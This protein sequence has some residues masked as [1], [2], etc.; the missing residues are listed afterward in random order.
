MKGI[1][2]FIK[3]TRPINLLFIA[4]TAFAVRFWLLAPFLE[5]I[6]AQFYLGI[7]WFVVFVL[8]LVFIAAGGNVINDYF[9]AKADIANKGDKSIV[10]VSLD[11]SVAI[12]AHQTLTALGLILGAI[13]AWKND[14]LILLSFH[15]FAAASLWFYS[16]IFKKQLLWGNIIVALLVACIPLSTGLFEIIPIIKSDGQRV[17]DLLNPQGI[18]AKF[19][20][21]ILFYWVAG[22]SFF[23]FISNLIREIVKDIEDQKGDKLIKRSTLP[24]V[25]G[26]KRAIW[27]VHAISLL[28]IISL[29]YL[30][31]HLI[32]RVFSKAYFIVL[33]AVPLVVANVF[34]MKHK[35]N[36]ASWMVK[37]IM[38]F[39]ISY[40]YFIKMQFVA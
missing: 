18:S 29:L 30:E 5:S 24:L 6:E 38:L 3:L 36:W 40:L 28:L 17:A 22:V 15:L 11:R 4:Y 31:S 35:V 14:T 7:E 39:G 9:D 2:S 19:Y 10:N 20:F 37:L 26:E 32:N 25:Y 8:S 27:V 34:L 33:I 1:I 13:Y 21:N 12:Y 23:A 16:L